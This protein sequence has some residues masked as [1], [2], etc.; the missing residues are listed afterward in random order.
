MEAEELV[1][2]LVTE[3]RR[4]GQVEA[5][6]LFALRPDLRKRLGDEKLLRFCRRYPE[7]VTVAE[8]KGGHVLRPVEEAWVAA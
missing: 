5:N 4:H 7:L 6:H 3:L 2:D 1:N 8:A